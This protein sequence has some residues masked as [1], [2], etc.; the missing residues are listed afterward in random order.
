MIYV[1]SKGM[2]VDDEFVL[3]G[4][5]NINQRS[6]E[7]TR[8]TEIAMGGYQ[9]H[10]SWAKK[11]SRPRGQPDDAAKS[12]FL[13][14]NTSVSSR[15]HSKKIHER[16]AA[17]TKKR[18]SSWSTHLPPPAPPTPSSSTARSG[19]RRVSVYEFGYVQ[20]PQGLITQEDLQEA[21]QDTATALQEMTDIVHDLMCSVAGGEDED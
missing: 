19:P 8:D 7:G 4:S 17:A 20:V 11:G 16:G 18:T 21:L 10:H 13:P 15:V 5:V 2:I 9:P 6:L 1:H 14:T 12:P 3:I